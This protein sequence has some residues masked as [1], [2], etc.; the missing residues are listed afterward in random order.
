MPILLYITN[1]Y[2]QYDKLISFI[3]YSRLLIWLT[4]RIYLFKGEK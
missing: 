3:T 1:N 4:I 2:I